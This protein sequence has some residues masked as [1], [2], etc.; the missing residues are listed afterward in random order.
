MPKEGTQLYHR[1]NLIYGVGV[2]DADYQTCK[3]VLIEYKNGKQKYD[4]IWVCPFLKCW[5]Q[6]LQRCYSDKYKK[7]QPSYVGCS[8]CEEWLTFSNFKRWMEQQDYEGKALDKDLLVSQNKTYSSETCVFVPRYINNFMLQSKARRGEHP[9]GVSYHIHHCKY[10]A[11]IC[12]GVGD[13]KKST[14]EFL[15]YF[16]F[17]EEAHRAWQEAKLLKTEIL[18]CEF[19]E[20]SRIKLGLQRVMSKLKNDLD[21]NLIT[22]FF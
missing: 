22:E 2:N 10:Q 5:Q 7:R 13:G 19:S 15:G 9:L 4:I 3:K 17:P 1:R 11:R 8:V 20:D 21:N 16:E 6:M 12:S 14:L 18:I